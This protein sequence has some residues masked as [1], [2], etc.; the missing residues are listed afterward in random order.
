MITKEKKIIVIGLTILA[1]GF[2]TLILVRLIEVIKSDKHNQASI[3][4]HEVD[5]IPS[6]DS[7]LFSEASLVRFKVEF[8]FQNIYRHVS[9]ILVNEQ[10]ELVLAEYDLAKKTPLPGL[11]HLKKGWNGQTVMESY[12]PVKLKDRGVFSFRLAPLQPLNNIFLTYYGD[13][14]DTVVSNDGLLHYRLLC[15]DLSI[16]NTADS[17]SDLVL[18]NDKGYFGPTLHVDIILYRRHDKIYFLFFTPIDYEGH[19]DVINASKLLKE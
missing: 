15:K 14:I 9:Y 1:V 17:P 6:E 5:T 10:Y 12:A 8:G 13:G 3:T 18:T 11:V 7:S 16:R 19:F 2:G 4:L